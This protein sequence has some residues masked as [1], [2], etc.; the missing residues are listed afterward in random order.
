MWNFT[1]MGCLLSFLAWL[2]ALVGCGKCCWI[3]S[4]L[5]RFVPSPL[6]VMWFSCRALK[7]RNSERKQG[8]LPRREHHQCPHNS[9]APCLSQLL[10]RD[11]GDAPALLDGVGDWEWPQLC[12]YICTGKMALTSPQGF[13]SS[14]LPPGPAVQ[15]SCGAGLILTLKP[16]NT[17]LLYPHGCGCTN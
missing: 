16:A 11:F 6:S 15:V 17:E 2:F 9:L 13:S 8:L 12:C 1:L 3:S 10:E 14:L 5:G 7:T 4:A